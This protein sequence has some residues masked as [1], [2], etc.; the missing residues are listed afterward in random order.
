MSPKKK[1]TAK[2]TRKKIAARPRAAKKKVALKKTAPAKAKKAQK[3]RVPSRKGR[4]EAAF[5][6]DAREVDTGEQLAGQSGDLQ[7][8]SDRETA[9]SESVQEL[10]EEGNAYEAEVIAGVE[11]AGDNGEKEVRTHEVL[12]DDV[13]DEYLNEQ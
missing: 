11:E 5:A 8:L 13:P 3:K 10:L 2:K 1:V 7:G 12:E 6:V 9:D 4:A